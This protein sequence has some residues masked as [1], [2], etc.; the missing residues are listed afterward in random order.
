LDEHPAVSIIVP[1][2]NR[3]PYLINAVD[4]ALAQTFKDWELLLADDG[5]DA[6]T[7]AYLQTLTERPQ[8]RVL[9]L[10]HSGNPPAVRNR[11]L[12]EARGTYVAFLDSDDV[13]NP[14]KLEMQIM[15]MD[16]KADRPWSY[17]GFATIDER[18]ALLPAAQTEH[19]PTEGPFLD[20]LLKGEAMIM[21]SSVAVRRDLLQSV[22]GY[23]EDLPVCG[24]YLLWIRL[25]LQSD[26]TLIPTPLVQVRR[27]HDRY[28]SNIDV[29]ADMQSMFGKLIESHAVPRLE[30][31]LRRRRAEVAAGA[32]V[33]YAQLK[34]PFAV[35]HTL[36]A[37]ASYSWRYRQWWR[38]AGTATLRALLTDRL[39]DLLRQASARC[40]LLRG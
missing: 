12:C 2:F 8:I 29:L 28:F 16:A 34:R 23:D 38:G 30:T 18:G 25:A 27:H 33:G 39:F 4:S 20:Q 11:A 19:Q 17:T 26:I 22:G 24:D 36:C 6:P 14:R 40:G 10:E 9:W 15:A 21:Q 31:V 37:S 35:L 5:S 13:W 7:R 3:L 1:T 32:A